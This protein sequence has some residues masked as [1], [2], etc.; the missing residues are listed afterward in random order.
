[1]DRKATSQAKEGVPVRTFVKQLLSH[2]EYQKTY[3][4]VGR[5]H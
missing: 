4:V 5:S 2:P 3:N 1:M